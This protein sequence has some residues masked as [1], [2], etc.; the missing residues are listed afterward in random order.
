MLAE[1]LKRERLGD[2]KRTVGA[3]IAVVLGRSCTDTRCVY[4]GKGSEGAGTGVQMQ[5]LEAMEGTD[6]VSHPNPKLPPC[7]RVF[8]K[9]SVQAPELRT[10]ELA[11]SFCCSPL[12]QQGC[13]IVAIL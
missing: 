10:S 7:G 1:C 2:D 5:L 8:S 4:G 3:W 13:F 9:Q 12:F 6:F 11:L